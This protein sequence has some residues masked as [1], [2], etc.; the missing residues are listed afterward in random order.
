MPKKEMTFRNKRRE[1]QGLVGGIGVVAG[2]G[3]FVGGYYSVP[4]TIVAMFGIW[5][6]GTLLVNLMTDPR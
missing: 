6:I 3:G 1:L 2:L 5:I 4:T